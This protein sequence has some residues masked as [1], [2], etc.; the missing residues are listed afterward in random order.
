MK[1]L[2][3][4]NLSFKLVV[5]L[6]DLYPDSA[7]VSSLALDTATD[8][9]VWTTAKD[10][11]YCIVT[12]DTD[13]NDL[14]STKSFPPKIIWIRLGNCTTTDVERVLRKQFEQLEAFETDT[15]LGLLE[16]WG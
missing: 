10:N 12:K 9:E 5:R 14:L 2:F 15:Q 13:F 11:G 8:I 7:H 16:L 6:Q 3:D 1:L 4:N